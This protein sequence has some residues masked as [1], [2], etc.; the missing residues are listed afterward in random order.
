[1]YEVRT[2]RTHIQD[3]YYYRSIAIA[4]YVLNLRTYVVLLGMSNSIFS[5]FF[6]CSPPLHSLSAMKAQ[7]S[8]SVHTNTN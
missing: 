6:G 7:T 3:S 2:R 4:P 8:P 5:I 1:M